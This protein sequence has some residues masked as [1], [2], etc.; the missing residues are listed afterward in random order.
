MKHFIYLLTITFSFVLISCGGDVADNAGDDTVEVTDSLAENTDQK[1][2]DISQ[3]D[4]TKCDKTKCDKTDCDSTNC[5]IADCDKKC[6]S[7][8]ECQKESCEKYGCTA[9]E[10]CTDECKANMANCEPEKCTKV[11]SD[12]TE[13]AC[14]GGE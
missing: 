13:T 5:N 6:T 2:C 4:K 12:S 7:Y 3:C 10:G 14:D 9:E 1:S 8:E 11:N